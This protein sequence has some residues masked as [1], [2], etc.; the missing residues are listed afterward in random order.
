MKPAG[1]YVY[2]LAI[3]TSSAPA[4]CIWKFTGP[5]ADAAGIVRTKLVVV[6]ESG[7]TAV[8]PTSTLV[9]VPFM[10]CV[11]TT[12]FPPANRP[13]F[14]AAENHAESY[15]NA[16]VSTTSGSPARCRTT[17]AAP[18]AKAVGMMKRTWSSVASVGAAPAA[19]PTATFVKTLP[20]P[21]QIS[22]A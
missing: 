20:N 5:G 10:S 15:S 1:L 6:A 14:G 3:V 17:S 8:P 22:T 12:S 21:C 13:L 19:P 7:A 16:L 4:R 2:A 11:T 9:T 18:A